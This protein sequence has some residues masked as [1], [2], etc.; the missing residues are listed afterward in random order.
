MFKIYPKANKGLPICTAINILFTVY[1]YIC[2]THNYGILRST[3]V[4]RFKFSNIFKYL[5]LNKLIIENK[6]AE[7]RCITRFCTFTATN[8]SNAAW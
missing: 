2:G 5:F 6:H 8:A 1:L 4:Y 7:S 3:Y